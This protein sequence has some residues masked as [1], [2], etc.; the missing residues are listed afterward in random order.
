MMGLLLL[1]FVGGGLALFLWLFLRERGDHRVD[2]LPFTPRDPDDFQK[3]Y[4][5]RPPY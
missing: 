1:G 2:F 3:Q 4:G 5:D